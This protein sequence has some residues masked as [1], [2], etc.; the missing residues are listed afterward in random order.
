MV[1]FLLLVLGIILLLLGIA[2]C[3]LPVIPGPPVS[4]VGLLLLKFTKFV[5]P[6][7]MD[8]FNELLWIFAFAAIVVTVLDY[9]VPVWGTKRFGGSKAGT[10]GA[11]IGVV[12]GLVLSPVT[13]PLGIIIGPFIG[14]VLGEVI[15][16]K[17]ERSSLRSGFGSFLG[18]LTGVI[19]KFIVSFL[20]TFYFIR[21]IIIGI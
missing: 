8:G 21:E 13:G 9:I 14:A 20:I 7:R 10:W 1:D 6:D 18:F 2:G 11:A 12:L 3:I 16:G 19:M 5:E 15:S 4:F 17:D